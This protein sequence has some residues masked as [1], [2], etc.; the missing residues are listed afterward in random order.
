MAGYTSPFT[1]GLENWEHLWRGRL[2]AGGQ[3]QT[4]TVG[5]FCKPLWSGHC[6]VP[7]AQGIE[8][9]I[10]LS[11]SFRGFLSALASLAENQS[12]SEYGDV[13]PC[14]P[15]GTGRCVADSLNPGKI[16]PFLWD[17]PRSV[18]WGKA[19]PGTVCKGC[20]LTTSDLLVPKS[21]ENS[22]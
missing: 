13:P 15:M 9:G 3:A 1:H 16:F 14:S 7:S 4:V 21:F 22:P 5:R 20:F 17:R 12:K 11:S 2:D 18:R 8:D 6:S 19:A 10:W